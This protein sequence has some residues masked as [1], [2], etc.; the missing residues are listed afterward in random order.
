MQ[1][2]EYKTAS[3][4]STASLGSIGEFRDSSSMALSTWS[5]HGVFQLFS[6]Q[7][8][9]MRICICICVCMYV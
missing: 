7:N 8:T 1:M 3:E 6:S 9:Y 4:F 5:S 2:N